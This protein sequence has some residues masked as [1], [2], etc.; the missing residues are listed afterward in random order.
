MFLTNIPTWT[1][2]AVDVRGSN[3]FVAIPCGLFL[4]HIV[5]LVDL[6]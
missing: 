1:A 3:V 4:L 6:Q 2:V 5:T